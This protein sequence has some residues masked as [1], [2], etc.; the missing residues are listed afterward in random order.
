[1]KKKLPFLNQA[2]TAGIILTATPAQF[3]AGTVD[4][5]KKVEVTTTVQNVSDK[6]IEITNVKTS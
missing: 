2:E 3:D 5:G 6:Q 1:M 4:E